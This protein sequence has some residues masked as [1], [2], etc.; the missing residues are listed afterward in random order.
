MTLTTPA[1]ILE[2]IAAEEIR[3]E[4]LQAELERNLTKKQQGIIHQHGWLNMY[5]PKEYG[6]LG[7]S[8]PQIL[9][10][11]ESLSWADGSAAWVVTLCSGAA[12]FIGFLDPGLV[13]EI[14]TNSKI[15]FAGSGAVTGTANK[16]RTGYEINGYWSH[17]TGALLA[18]VFT[19]NCKVLNDG[20]QLIGEN[21]EPV[22]TSFL[23][24]KNEVIIHET[25]NSMGMIATGSHA[26]EVKNK[27]IPINRAF[28][29]S[30]S[31][32]FL[33]NPVYQYP[34]LQLAETT[35]SVNLSGMASRFLDLCGEIISRRQVTDRLL[36]DN[37][38]LLDSLRSDFF[39]KTDAAWEALLLQSR[40]P[41]QLLSDVTG[42]SHRLAVG[43]RKIINDLYPLCGLAAADTRSE[44]NRVFRN[45]HT[46][47]QHALFRSHR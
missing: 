35:L 20:I 19:V 13:Q 40:I 30:P 26:M 38:T 11:E 22:V 3:G 31:T 45:F 39:L 6:G 23:L 12:W 42:V 33:K 32:A 7:V 18:D 5:V 4:G 28:T 43:C 46:A 36:D 10:M 44:I 27:T 24:R 17:A 25:W 1:E 2:S 14:F 41:D 37:T 29:I 16:T 9:R 8:F 21:G 15:C 47:G 34:F